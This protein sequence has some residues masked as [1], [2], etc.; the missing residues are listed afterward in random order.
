MKKN[1]NLKRFLVENKLTEASR[2]NR[3][4]THFG[5]VELSDRVRLLSESKEF[6]DEVS[7]PVRRR[8]AEIA[9]KISRDPNV[10]AGRRH[11]KG[12][13]SRN[14]W[15]RLRDIL[16]DYGID[17]L[18]D[19]LEEPFV[20]DYLNGKTGNFPFDKCSRRE[21]KQLDKAAKDFQAYEKSKQETEQIRAAQ[22]D[23]YNGTFEEGNFG[24]DD[25]VYECDFTDQP[26]EEAGYVSDDD[27]ED[28]E[29]GVPHGNSKAFYDPRASRAAKKDIGS[30]GFNDDEEE[31][32]DDPDDLE[33]DDLGD[34]LDGDSLDEPMESVSLSD[35]NYNPE[36]VEWDPDFNI[37]EYVSQWPE[38]KWPVIIRVLQQGLNQAQK[39]ANENGGVWK[40]GLYMYRCSRTDSNKQL[41][42]NT[43]DYKTSVTNP[44]GK[45]D[46]IQMIAK[47]KPD[48]KA[49]KD[50]GWD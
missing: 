13:Q 39:E 9:D 34:N 1:F 40:R 44:M 21:I 46:F 3:K 30:S 7:W 11:I 47:I 49:L 16:R 23:I 24:D 29:I 10:P 5:K 19:R 17:S 27:F 12:L 38:N 2:G 32:F 50:L 26:L 37:Q 36:T 18:L 35:L 22:K 25:P 14:L 31:S 42:Y 6:L 15:P 33:D 48:P 28:M 45:G 20:R 41:G 8:A 43:R 4:R